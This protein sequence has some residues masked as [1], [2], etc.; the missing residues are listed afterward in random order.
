VVNQKT[1][2]PIVGIYKITSPSGKVYIGQS[3]DIKARRSAYSRN[4]TTKQ[5]KLRNSI[6]KHG[7]DKH[8]F[9]ILIRLDE[10][11]QLWLDML[12]QSYMDSHRRAGIELLNIREAGS[13]GRHKKESKLKLSKS[14]KGKATGRVPWNKGKT[15]VYTEETRQQIKDARARQPKINYTPTMRARMSV[16]AKK[17]GITS[18]ARESMNI[19][20][21][22]AYLD[23]KF[24]WPGSKITPEEAREIKSR[25]VP[26]VY[27][28]LRLAKEFGVSK[29][30][31]LNIV[32]GKRLGGA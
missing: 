26:R 31:I 19:A 5:P 10:A 13:R 23:G 18:A 3:W 1:N 24:L 27:S 14:L 11:D 22:Q 29:S 12:E 17:R 28:S 6:L 4:I 9:E 30:V 25:Y 21:K 16:A 32:N 7:W 2:T 8:S 15:N 20:R